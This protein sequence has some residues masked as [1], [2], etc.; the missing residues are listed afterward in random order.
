MPD[1]TG[2]FAKEAKQWSKMRK[3]SNIDA[4]YRAWRNEYKKKGIIEFAMKELRVDPKNGGALQLSD[5]QKQFLIDISEGNTKYAI[6]SAGRGTGKSF[7]LS[8]LI[9]WF[10]FVTEY[11][12]IG[13]LAGN[14]KQSGILDEYVKGWIK[15][16]PKL[17]S[18][19]TKNVK[20]K[21]MTHAQSGV[22]FCALSDTAVRGIHG[23]ILI[24]DEEVAAEEAGGEAIVKTAEWTVNTAKNMII[25]RSSTPQS[26]GGYFIETWGEA[27]NRDDPKLN[28][29]HDYVRY[30]W[31]SVRHISGNKNPYDTY[32]DTNINHWFSNLPWIPD[33]NIRK[34]R[35]DKSN[36]E[37]LCLTEDSIIY[38]DNKEIKEIKKGDYVLGNGKTRVVEKMERKYSGELITVK[39]RNL[40]STTFTPN[41]P[42]ATVNIKRKMEY[43]NP[44]NNYKT[45][46][47]S[48]AK[49][50][51]S[52]ITFK[53]ADELTVDDYL[54]IPRNN[55]G[56]VHVNPD[57][58]YLL[59]WY[60]AE[61]SFSNGQITFSLNKKEQDIANK[62]SKII[63]KYFDREA[64]PY[65]T[66][67]ALQVSFRCKERANCF[68]QFGNKAWNKRI[69][70]FIRDTWDEESLRIF[71]S[72][73]V[74][75]DGYKKTDKGL[76]WKVSTVSRYLV[77]DLSEILFKIGIVPYIVKIPAHINRIENR[78]I[79]TKDSW[80]ISWSY[81]RWISNPKCPFYIVNDEYIYVKIESISKKEVKDITVH[82]F[83]TDQHIYCVPFV[84]HNCEALG[85][86]SLA[87][88]LVFNPNDLERAICKECGDECHPYQGKC[89]LLQYYLMKEGVHTDDIMIPDDMNNIEA[90]E[91]TIKNALK[92]LGE[93]SLGI[94]WGEKAPDCYNVIARFNNQVFVLD[95]KELRGQNTAEKI[96]TAQSM[97]EKW[98]VE[99]IVPDPE[100]WAYFEALANLGYS[101]ERIWSG[102]GATDK[103][104]YV[105]WLKKDFERGRI[106]IPQAFTWLIKSLRELT[107]GDNG[108]IVKRGD[109]SFDSL[110]YARSHYG[111]VDEDEINNLKET[112]EGVKIWNKDFK[113]QHTPLPFKNISNG[114]KINESTVDDFNPFDE[115]YLKRKRNESIDSLYFGVNL[116]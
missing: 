104:K 15:L 110:L 65:E 116:W 68:Y 114:N 102:G 91:A 74:D 66:R 30:Q 20:S 86:M 2:M 31:S 95:S 49:P 108:K 84:V 115:G 57:L 26:S 90:N 22:V 10:I 94:D 21:I 85:V 111:A 42:I 112:L 60:L 53:R 46:S 103:P 81:N 72:A 77:Y 45:G 107:Y 75:G 48:G 6:I 106:H 14:S 25:I 41:H 32:K 71:I 89:I 63:N 3:S 47:Y 100:Q 19:C 109:H 4:T 54:V 34:I 5:E 52:E 55:F 99:T 33:E 93:R 40:L 18:F 59:G 67:T 17:E 87:S 37:W 96:G 101:L 58:A 78:E 23:S 39:P 64:K 50:V 43:N 73:Y 61:G 62:L 69:P 82:N 113:E 8:I 79:R 29:E 56:K 27:K 105:M 44:K 24:I 88:G 36:D 76:T 70:K 13:V 97:C 12:N 51:I 92:Y 16:N 80:S 11:S 98:G 1:Y 7:S 38:G 35:K 28:P 83:E 9:A